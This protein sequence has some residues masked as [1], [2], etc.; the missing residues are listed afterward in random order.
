[1]RF[2]VAL[3]LSLVLPCAAQTP[4]VPGNLKPPAGA[5][6]L[7]HVHATGDQV[8]LCDGSAWVLSH[9]DAKLF[10]DSGQQVGTHYAGPTWESSDHSRVAGKPVANATPDPDSIPWLL[11]QAK[12]HQGDGAMQ[13]VAFVQRLNTKG[14]KAPAAGCDAAHKGQEARSPYSADYLFY[15]AP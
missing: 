5:T 6:L 1:M 3:T 10:D 9:P 2:A 11:V 8:Y 12:D 7:L 14:G 4:A 13:K 15:A